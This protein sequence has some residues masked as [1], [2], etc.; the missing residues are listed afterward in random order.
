LALYNEYPGRVNIIN[1]HAGSLANPGSGQPDFRTTY[2]ETYASFSGIVAW[3]AGMMN[4]IVWPGAYNEPPY[5][6]QNPPNR[7]ALRRM[8]WYDASYPGQGAGAYII[9]KGGLSPVN[10]GVSTNWNAGTR[11]LTVYVELYY[12]SSDTVNNEI[13]VLFLENG[14]IG[15]QAGG[16]SSYVHNHIL[17][18]MLTGQW[19]DIVTTPTIGTL[20][21][22]TYQYI[23]P[24]EYNGITNNI[25]N[26]DIT[27]FVTQ[28]DHKTIH[29]GITIPANNGSTLINKNTVKLC[30]VNV[31]PN[32][33]T[34]NSTLSF[35][36]KTT[37]NINIEI[38]NTLGEN[39]I[40]KDLGILAMGNHTI[41][42][43]FFDIDKLSKG[44]YILKINTGN[45]TS[46]IKVLK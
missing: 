6:P 8:G 22:R 39:I 35:Y 19:G 38:Y 27:V 40:K 45:S 32:P 43:N 2:G 10:I 42:L 15:Y 28:N 17:R 9:L 13:N 12:T 21:T 5:F 33:L 23:V 1:I 30:D 3:P 34:D 37:E 36:L 24:T 25:N 14:V 29:T 11:L 41:T 46:S 44:I 20:I 18:N 4:R 7:L 31:F 16:G 26:C